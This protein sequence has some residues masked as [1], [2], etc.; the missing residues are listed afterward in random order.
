MCTAR[1]CHTTDLLRY[2]A[3]SE[4]QRVWACGGTMTHP[5]HPCIDQCVAAIQFANGHVGLLDP[6]RRGAGAVHQQVL[7]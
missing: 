6:G 5:G 7:F 4:P 2:F 1:A 3:G